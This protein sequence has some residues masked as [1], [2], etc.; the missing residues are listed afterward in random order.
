MHGATE[1]GA[2]GVIHQM[3]HRSVHR[4]TDGNR[5][6]ITFATSICVRFRSEAAVDPSLST[7][8]LPNDQLLG[9]A[10]IESRNYFEMYPG[11]LVS[12]GHL[13]VSFL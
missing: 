12:L 5:C 1:T 4:G 2:R 7:V 10:L 13:T 3:S 9:S 8:M 6:K 11:I